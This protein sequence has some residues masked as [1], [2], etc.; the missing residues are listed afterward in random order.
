LWINEKKLCFTKKLNDISDAFFIV[1]KWSFI[2]F[3]RVTPINKRLAPNLRRLNINWIANVVTVEP[4][5]NVITV[6]SIEK[7]F[8]HDVLFSLTNFTLLAKIA[9]PY[10]LQNL[11]SMLSS[12]CLYSLDVNWFV[13]TVVSLPETSA[14]LSDTFQQFKGPVPIEL[15]LSLEENMYSIRAVTVPRMDRSLCVYSYLHKNTM[16]GYIYK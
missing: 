2:H 8:E 14:I 9:G 13:G 6:K 1:A 10:V 7:L 3:S 12:Q 15:E 11:L 5:E 4:I 16:H